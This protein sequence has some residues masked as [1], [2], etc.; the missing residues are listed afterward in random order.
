MPDFDEND[1]MADT[2]DND[3]V[4]EFNLIPLIVS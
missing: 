1:D 3:E 4:E 2:E